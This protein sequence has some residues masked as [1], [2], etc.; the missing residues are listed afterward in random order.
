MLK[1]EYNKKQKELEEEKLRSLVS[2]LSEDDKERVYNEGIQ[3]QEDQNK[4][5][6]SDC[7]PSLSVADV[8][9]TTPITELIHE[10]HGESEILLS[11]SLNTLYIDRVHSHSVLCTA[12]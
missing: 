12:N 2:S 10:D 5:Q 6:T 9:K 8:D 3:L 4:H 11:L 1:V 7:L